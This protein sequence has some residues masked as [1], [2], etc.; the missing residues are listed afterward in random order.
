MAEQA[1][2][3]KN[4]LILGS[5]G[6]SGLC[7]VEQA[8]EREYH[9]TVCD[10]KTEKLPQKFLENKNLT[11]YKATLPEAPAV[12]EPII[13]KFDAIISLLGPNSLKGSGDELED[14]YKWMIPRLLKIP[15]ANRPY[16]MVVGTQTITDPKDVFS[17]I[18]S[19][20][21]FIIGMIAKGAKHMIQGIGRQ[22]TPFI[23]G[24]GGEKKVGE[25]RLDCVLF[26]LNMVKD[27]VNRE[28]AQA[29]YVG[30][31]AFKP[32][33]E[34]PQLAKWLLDELE[35]QN[36]NRKAPAVWGEG[37]GLVSSITEQVRLTSKSQL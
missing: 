19:I 17:L 20:H 28:G 3:G 31:G 29:G 5:T 26:R 18:T 1:Q 22:W 34:R 12:L 7:T 33:L 11:V 2:Q 15:Q 8:L 27:G 16:V 25:E 24:Q 37:V 13:E 32:Q 23:D 21:V 36:W 9:I 6:P 30:A 4:I 35:Q 14:F 10:R